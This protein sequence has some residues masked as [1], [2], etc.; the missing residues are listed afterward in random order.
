MIQLEG[1]SRFE[2][3]EME[4][5]QLFH[6]G[7]EGDSVIGILTDKKILIYDTQECQIVIQVSLTDICPEHLRTAKLEKVKSITNGVIEE[8]KY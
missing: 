2:L 5:R 1:F 7:S 8:G 4:I 3:R 6:I